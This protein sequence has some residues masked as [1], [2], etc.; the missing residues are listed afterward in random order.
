[1]YL[2]YIRYVSCQALIF[3]EGYGAS[4]G[5]TLIRHD[6]CDEAIRLARIL[7]LLVRD[8]NTQVPQRQTAEALGLPTPL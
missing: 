6:L 5:D 4:Q 3:S 2:L 1:M 7:T 8:G